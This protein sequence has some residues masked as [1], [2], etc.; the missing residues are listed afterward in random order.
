MTKTGSPYSQPVNGR[1]FRNRRSNNFDWDKFYGSEMNFNTLWGNGFAGHDLPPEPTQA[2]D[3]QAMFMAN[4]AT[5]ERDTTT[6]STT[7]RPTTVYETTSTEPWR[8]ETRSE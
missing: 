1:G 8:F 7:M 3:P 5:T 4:Y 2:S 6:K